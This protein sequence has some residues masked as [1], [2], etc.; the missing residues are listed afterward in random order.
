MRKPKGHKANCKCPF[1]KAY[2]KQS[3]KRS[4]PKKTKTKRPK[5]RKTKKKGSRRRSKGLVF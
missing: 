3:R 1:C 4:K 5:R 2:R